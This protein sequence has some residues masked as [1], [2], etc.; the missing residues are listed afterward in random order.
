ME[1]RE[2]W[3]KAGYLFWF[4]GLMAGFLCCTISDVLQLSMTGRGHILAGTVLLAAVSLY[5]RL[6]G[7]LRLY[8]TIALP[9]VLGYLVHAL[10]GADLPQRALDAWKYLLYGT[11]LAEDAALRLSYVLVSLITA[12]SAVLELWPERRFPVRILLA[13]GQGISLITR[14]VLARPVSK[15]GVC[16]ALTYI[17]CTHVL[18]LRRRLRPGRSGEDLYMVGLTPFLGV[19]LASLLLLP[20]SGKPYDWQWVRD[21]YHTLE[22]RITIGLENLR[23]ASDGEVEI[24]FTG[25]SEE[26][27]LFPALQRE[28]REL[29]LLKAAAGRS[30]SVYLTAETYSDFTGRG[31]ELQE[32]YSEREMAADAFETIYALERYGR[33]GEEDAF[34]SAQ[35][36][37]FYQNYRTRTM[38]LPSKVW[39]LKPGEK[40][41][42]YRV[43]GPVA[44]FDQK[45]GY[46]TSY[47]VRYVRNEIP[48]E[49]LA[50]FLEADLPEEE[51]LRNRIL[52]DYFREPVTERDLEEYHADTLLACSEAPVLSEGVRK[53]VAD[54]TEGAASGSE[55]LLRIEEALAELPYNPS[56]GAL[57]EKV[58]DA[59]SFL[60]YFL[61]EKKEG[62]CTYFATAFALLARSEGYP[63]RYVQGFLVPISRQGDTVV[64][65]YMAHA[66][67][68]VWFEG[69]GYVAF[70]P[71]PGHLS[72]RYLP[73]REKKEQTQGQGTFLPLYGEEE[74]ALQVLPAEPDPGP[75]LSWIPVAGKAL[76]LLVLLGA[77]FLGILAAADAVR[78]KRR[79]P[80]EKYRRSVRQNLKILG[81]LGYERA[82]NETCR[83]LAERLRSVRPDPIE[84]GFLGTYERYLY[85]DQTV[86]D[87]MLEETRAATRTLLGVLKE[88]SGKRYPL[89]LL[90][91]RLERL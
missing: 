79:T 87:A 59:G 40:M 39:F 24:A 34:R 43:E 25:I 28:D 45:A 81:Y 29:V 46:G 5:L 88:Q 41:R 8:V 21:L 62:Y 69:K 14:M 54:V 77:V 17:L 51:D 91:L 50:A 35:L 9:L 70:E 6:R 60:D 27:D 15:P 56:P 85:T 16:F 31:W 32:Q 90:R 26:A 73:R 63:A 64:R 67:P 33:A 76:L 78:E 53:W 84:G 10:G 48:R 82:E 4:A 55:R 68:E 44:R 71:T 66:W 7:R 57:P 52:R 1:R 11:P 80:A 89:Y 3:V 18:L 86:S 19:L 30:R 47:L 13:A 61:L 37:I 72:D 74:E 38:L 22:D 58:Q 65:S 49:D 23:H 2:Y 36:E 75:D 83:E 42:D 20:A 12:G